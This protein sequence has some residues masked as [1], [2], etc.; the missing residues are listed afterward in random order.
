M[1]SLVLPSSYMQS[2]IRM[3]SKQP[4]KLICP[5]MHTNSCQV[6]SWTSTRDSTIIKLQSLVVEG[7]EYVVPC[8]GANLWA[9]SRATAT[10]CCCICL[11]MLSRVCCKTLCWACT[12]TKVRPIA[13]RGLSFTG[14][15]SSALGFA[16]SSWF[17]C[18]AASCGNCCCGGGSAMGP[19]RARALWPAP[20]G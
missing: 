14:A 11:W 9:A 10:C 6:A 16:A 18:T 20:A 3:L 7:E 12:S 5:V 8:G 17:V 2:V 1:P 15:G 13:R 19:S 4:L